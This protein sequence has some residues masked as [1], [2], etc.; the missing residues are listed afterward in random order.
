MMFSS[1][2]MNYLLFCFLGRISFVMVLVMRLR[3]RKLRKFMFSF[4]MFRSF[5]V[6]GF[7]EN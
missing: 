1:R 6:L 2:V 3:R 5:G 7:C 4:F